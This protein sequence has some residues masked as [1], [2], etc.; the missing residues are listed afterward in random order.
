[1]QGSKEELLQRLADQ[2]KE[3]DYFRQ[4]TGHKDGTIDHLTKALTLKNKGNPDDDTQEKLRVQVAQ[5][6]K[7]LENMSKQLVQTQEELEQSRICLQGMQTSSSLSTQ[8]L[9]QLQKQLQER[10]REVEAL[11]TL[12]SQ[13]DTLLQELRDS[14]QSEATEVESMRSAMEAWHGNQN[15]AQG[16]NDDQLNALQASVQQRGVEVED[17][18]HQL[19]ER[20]NHVMHLEEELS[21]ALQQSARL[22]RSVQ[23]FEKS[24]TS[25]GSPL[26]DV[27]FQEDVVLSDGGHGHDQVHQW[28]RPRRSWTHA[29]MTATHSLPETSDTQR[30]EAMHVRSIA[31]STASLRGHRSVSPLATQ[32][33]DGALRRRGNDPER[34]PLRPL[35]PLA[36]RPQSIR[37]HQ[38][39]KNRRQIMDATVNAETKPQWVQEESA[40]ELS[41]SAAKAPEAAGDFKAEPCT[42]RAR[43]AVRGDASQP[44][45]RPSSVPPA[46]S[47]TGAV[48]LRKGENSPT[49]G[50]R[51][52]LLEVPRR[53]LASPEAKDCLA[54][55]TTSSRGGAASVS[56]PG[57]NA[58]PS[59]TGNRSRAARVTSP[60]RANEAPAE[61]GNN[62]EAGPV[63]ILR[64]GPPPSTRQAVSSPSSQTGSAACASQNSTT[65]TTR[66]IRT[67]AGF[68]GAR[69]DASPKLQNPAQASPTMARKGLLNSP[70]QE[71]PCRWNTQDLAA[72]PT[73]GASIAVPTAH[74]PGELHAKFESMRDELKRRRSPGPNASHDL[75]RSPMRIV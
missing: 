18:R 8:Q 26:K 46:S 33:F 74:G 54:S 17:L 57:R 27:P 6:E 38:D 32:A 60:S 58:Q 31:G 69:G 45:S 48:S 52:T 68:A 22:R 75:L 49:T 41:P 5:G 25:P 34:I 64:H 24:C 35:D 36:T 15:K 55:S 44:G 20:D 29:F 30:F 56:A 59:D 14:Q 67:A 70:A 11:K 61:G 3:L 50:C 10:D 7:K 73:K 47:S 1:M 51:R 19:A 53:E 37:E 43:A 72:L 28:A 63:R 40:P 71:Q 4:V 23:M 42:G 13:K 66:R 9:Q 65:S 2:Q 39:S 12:L 21:A 16:I 62:K